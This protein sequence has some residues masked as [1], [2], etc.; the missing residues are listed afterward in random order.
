MFINHQFPIY[1]GAP[2]DKNPAKS[3]GKLV[4]G[5]KRRKLKMGKMQQNNI[6]KIVNDILSYGDL[7]L[8]ANKGIGKTNALMVLTRHFRALPKTRVIIFEDFP[9]WSLEFDRIPYLVV[10]DSWVQEAEHVIDVGNY[11]LRHERDYTVLMGSQIKAVLKKCKDILFVSEIQDIE[12]QAFFIYSIIQWFYRKNYLRKFKNY[13]SLERIVFF[14]EESQNVFDSS[15]I[16]KKIFNRLRKIYSV[17]RNLEIHFILA[18]QRL[19]D[20][21]TKIRGR[22]R[23]LLG[24][25]S[26]DDYELKIRRILRHSR[27]KK[28]ILNFK[29]GEFLYTPLDIKVKFPLFQQVGKPYEINL[30]SLM[31]KPQRKP[32]PNI[33]VRI[34][35]KFGWIVEEEPEIGEQPEFEPIA[36]SEHPDSESEIEIDESE[37]YLDE[38]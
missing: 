31:P 18:S 9:K 20:L 28:E 24:N 6:E 17:A 35:Q 33:V 14:I 13:N 12:R 34:L 22:T 2:F 26:L 32:K 15:T 30:D 1:L 21:N 5:W 37:E 3:K 38:W 8:V 19:Q 36:D 23:L 4:N 16:S 10:K 27:F 25:P 29:V 7:L 11:F